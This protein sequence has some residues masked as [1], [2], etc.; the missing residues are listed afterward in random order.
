M[1]ARIWAWTGLL[2]VA[3]GT[4]MVSDIVLRLH[5]TK[6]QLHAAHVDPFSWDVV[7]TIAMAIAMTGLIIEAGRAFLHTDDDLA[8]TH[9]K[10]VPGVKSLR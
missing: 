7:T 5:Y 10:E 8:I 6:Q 3:F 4:D 2:A 9:V 1:S